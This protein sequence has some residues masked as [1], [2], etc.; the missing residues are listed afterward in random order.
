MT[1]QELAK[2]RA[3]FLRREVQMRQTVLGAAIEIGQFAVYFDDPNLIN[4][5]VDK[6]DAVSV[7]QVKQV[8][9]KY[10]VPVERAVVTTLP[11]AKGAAASAGR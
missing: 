4:T 11:A 7:S 9:E 5:I 3:Q 6:F 2:A 10:L 1:A 8:A